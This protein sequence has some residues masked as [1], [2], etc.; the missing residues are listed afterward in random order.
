MGAAI[1]A[2][3][4][5]ALAA[6][7]YPLVAPHISRAAVKATK[8]MQRCCEAYGGPALSSTWSW[9]PSFPSPGRRSGSGAASVLAHG[10]LQQLQ[11]DVDGAAPLTLHGCPSGRPGG[12]QAAAGATAEPQREVVE[13]ATVAATQQPAVILMRKGEVQG[14]GTGQ[15]VASGLPKCD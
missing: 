6:L 3:N 15:K 2:V 4:V 1:L 9:L 11:L 7:A 10:T 12:V 14:T 13:L 5:G 8:A